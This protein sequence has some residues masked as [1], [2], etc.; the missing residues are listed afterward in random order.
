MGVDVATMSEWQHVWIQA[1]QKAW[2]DDAFALELKS[3]PRAAL[4]KHYNFEVPE[5]MH[6]QVVEQKDL[7]K[8]EHSCLTLALPP[9]PNEKDYKIK[10]ASLEEA[11]AKNCCGHPCC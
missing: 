1:V 7:P 5:H 2:A 9:K 4:S 6:F 3:D 11:T 10:T 8:G